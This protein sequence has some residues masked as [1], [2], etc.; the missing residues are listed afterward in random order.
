LIAGTVPVYLGDSDQLKK[1]LPDPNAAIHVSDF[2]DNLK[3]LA[4][5]LNYL[6]K[7]ETAYEIHRSSWRQSFSYEKNIAKSHLME[8]SW[9]CRV[10][11]WA[12]MLSHTAASKIEQQE[13]KC[14]KAH[15]NSNTHSNSNS[16]SS[17]SQSTESTKNNSNSNGNAANKDRSRG[18]GRGR[19]H[20]HEKSPK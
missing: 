14:G 4:D 17:Q 1:L 12:E 11:Q 16:L 18:P 6:T 19:H 5:Y 7:N 9:F 3:G 2:K 13:A 20:N 8:Q 15:A 10:C